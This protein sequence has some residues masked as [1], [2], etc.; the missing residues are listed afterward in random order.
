LSTYVFPAPGAPVRN[1]FS[2]VLRMAKAVDWSMWGIITPHQ[3]FG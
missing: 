1:T 2:P 3:K